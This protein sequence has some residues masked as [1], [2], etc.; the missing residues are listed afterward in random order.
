[1]P[2]GSVSSALPS[3]AARLRFPAD[4]AFQRDLRARVDAYFTVAVARTAAMG[5]LGVTP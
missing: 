5:L 2:D 4:S 3:P 1:M